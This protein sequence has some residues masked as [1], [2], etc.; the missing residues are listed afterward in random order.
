MPLGILELKSISLASRLGSL[1]RTAEAL[2]ITQPALSRRISEAERSLGIKLFDR[3]P[4]GVKPT[5]A[6]L[7]FLRHAEVA[8]TSISD[9]RDAALDVQNRRVR[10]VSIGLLEVFCDNFL[11]DACRATAAGIKGASISFTIAITSTEVSADLLSGATKL[12]LRYRRDTSPQFEAVWLADDPVVAICAALHPLAASGHATI[13]QLEQVQW[14][15]NPIA[16]DR[17]ATALLGDMSQ[18]GFQNWKTMSAPTLFSRI[19]LVEAGFGVALVRRACVEDQLQRGS[20]IELDTPLNSAISV[21]LAWRRG[22][23]LGEAG[24]YLRDQ[25]VEKYHKGCVTPE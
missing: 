8:L 16:M 9:G 7:A 25:L 5:D 14:I 20:V 12:G 19:A 13:E 1:S 3:L 24:E 18:T 17:D 4:R 21:F 22:S 23:Y 10:A 6:C 11:V 15:G 2:N